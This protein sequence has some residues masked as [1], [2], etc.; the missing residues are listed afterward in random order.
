MMKRTIRACHLPFE[1]DWK[2]RLSF[3]FF[4]VTVRLVVYCSATSDGSFLSPSM[5][6]YI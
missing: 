3:W 1:G 2:D 5:R 6:N 4:I